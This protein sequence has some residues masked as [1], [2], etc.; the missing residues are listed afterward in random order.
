M[1]YLREIDILD[2][3]LN[4]I[5]ES[6][7][8]KDEEIRPTGGIW[9]KPKPKKLR[10]KLIEINL[11]GGAAYTFRGQK[12]A[13][14]HININIQDEDINWIHEVSELV[15]L[16]MDDALISNYYFERENEL[17]IFN[18]SIYLYM[19]NLR[20]YFSIPKKKIKKKKQ[21]LPPIQ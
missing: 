4:H 20:Y 10:E 17:N 12:E 9:I 7:L 16:V 2:V 5:K 21:L 6:I 11:L 1:E 13:T 19:G 8:Y 18:L 15:T 14:G 3:V